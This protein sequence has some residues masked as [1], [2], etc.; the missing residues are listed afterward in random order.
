MVSQHIQ[1]VAAVTA[2]LSESKKVWHKGSRWVDKAK[3]K[4]T[5]S[6][7]TKEGAQLEFFANNYENT[8]YHEWEGL[9]GAFPGQNPTMYFP[10]L[11]FVEKLEPPTLPQV[12]KDKCNQESWENAG[13]KEKS[14]ARQ[15]NNSLSIKQ[16]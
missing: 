15:N 10:R 2:D 6:E 12:P 7:A 11:L 8:Q 5:K 9:Y 14:Q 16:S 1:M 13:T 4:K 3:E